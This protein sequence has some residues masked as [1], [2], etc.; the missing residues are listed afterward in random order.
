MSTAAAGFVAIAQDNI[1]GTDVVR[2]LDRVCARPRHLVVLRPS[3]GTLEAR[4][5]GRR[6]GSGKVAYRPPYSP[7]ANDLHVAA[8]PS[9][10]G[11]WLDTS[12]WSPTETVDQIV[13]RSTEALVP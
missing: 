11:L 6:E 2:W 3:V 7:K 9:H 4:D 12:G 5:A 8:T 10:L 13:E 1:Y